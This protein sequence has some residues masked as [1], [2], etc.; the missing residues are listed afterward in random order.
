MDEQKFIAQRRKDLE[1]S[2][3]YFAPQNKNERECWVADAF[4]RNLGIIPAKGEIISIK[5]DPP[6]VAF[7]NARFEIKEILDPGRRRHAEYKQELE[8]AQNITEA[9]DLLR[10]FTPKDMSLGEI[11]RLCQKGAAS[12]DKYSSDFKRGTDLLLYVNLRHVMDVTEQPYPDT[13]EL[14]ATGW[15]SISFVMGRRSGCFYARP[16]AP[17][18]IRQAVGRVSHHP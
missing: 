8:R 1:A 16:D 4:V 17:G 13:T 6:D 14:E 15:R 7:R 3:E 5:Q 12:L 18:F 9:K 11:Y 10:P 2:V